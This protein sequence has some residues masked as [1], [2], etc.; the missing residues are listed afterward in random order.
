MPFGYRKLV[1]YPAATPASVS[2]NYRKLSYRENV[3]TNYPGAK[4]IGLD[5][6]RSLSRPTTILNSNKDY[7]QWHNVAT[8]EM[9]GERREFVWLDTPLV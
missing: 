5:N 9:F 1:R 6:G 4:S 8:L 7:D 2:E 3:D